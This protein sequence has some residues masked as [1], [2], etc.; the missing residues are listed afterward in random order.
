MRNAKISEIRN[1]VK[2]F[3][4]EYLTKFNHIV[5]QHVGE[6]GVE[7]LGIAVGKRN[8]DAHETPPDITFRELEEAYRIAI[9]V[10]DAVRQT[11]G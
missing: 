6:E 3:G 10:I 2:L 7:K 9:L 8:E 1:T 4:G 11:F 5:D